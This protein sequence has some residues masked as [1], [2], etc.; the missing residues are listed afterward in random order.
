MGLD[1]EMQQQVLWERSNERNEHSGE[2]PVGHPEQC[3]RLL[4]NHYR[5]CGKYWVPEVLLRGVVVPGRASR[6]CTSC[7][8]L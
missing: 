3:N 5:K 4:L 8:A 7:P 2:S 1:L 6:I